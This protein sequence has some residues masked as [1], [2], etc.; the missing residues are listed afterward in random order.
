[1][2]GSHVD[3]R[4]RIPRRSLRHG[5][6]GLPQVHE[7]WP[8]ITRGVEPVEVELSPNE[9][10]LAEARIGQMLTERGYELSGHPPLEVTPAKARRLRLHSRYYRAMFR[11]SRYG[12]ALFLADAVARRF[13]PRSWQLKIKQWINA[14]ETSLLT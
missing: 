11:R 3:A 12:N 10:R 5:D 4:L 8:A 6:V 9:I 13:G 2:P 1:M 14:I 7:L